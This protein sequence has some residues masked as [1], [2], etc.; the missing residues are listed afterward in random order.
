M[1]VL[2]ACLV[3]LT[4]SDLPHQKVDDGDP[5]DIEVEYQGA[6]IGMYVF[7]YVRHDMC[8]GTIFKHMKNQSNRIRKRHFFGTTGR[9]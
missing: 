9:S 1:F 5:L 3:L 2:V 4:Y 8:Y 6:T 7:A